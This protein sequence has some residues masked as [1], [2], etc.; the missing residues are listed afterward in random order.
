[1]WLNRHYIIIIIF[2]MMMMMMTVRGMHHRYQDKC[3]V[4][5]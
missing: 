5:A 4:G 3:P 2:K 1:M